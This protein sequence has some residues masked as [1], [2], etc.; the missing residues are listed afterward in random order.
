MPVITTADLK[1]HLN[2][3]GDEDDALLVNKATAAEGWI[4]KYIGQPFSDFET[5]PEPLKEAVRQ[6]AAHLYENREAS[7][8]GISANELP[9]GLLDLLTPY[10]GWAF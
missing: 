2:L 5:I 9:F 1:S 10:R 7:L 4:E 8:V 3:T 6:L